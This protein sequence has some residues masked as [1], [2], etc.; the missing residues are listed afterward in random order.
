VDVRVSEEAA[1]L[2]FSVADEDPGFA[3]EGSQATAGHGFVNMA[4][5]LGAIGGMLGWRSTPGAGTTV[6][7][8]IPLRAP[9][10]GFTL[11]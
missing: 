8:S 3:P 1:E 2:H 6:A 7:G 5:R 9:S 11:S 10:A 4:D